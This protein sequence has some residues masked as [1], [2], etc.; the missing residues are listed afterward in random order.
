MSNKNQNNNKRIVYPPI[1]SQ[2]NKQGAVISVVLSDDEDVKWIWTH[3]SNGESFV[4]GYEII[5]KEVLA[6]KINKNLLKPNFTGKWILDLDKSNLQSPP[7]DSSIF[8]INSTLV[9]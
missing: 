3:L 1:N 9:N 7:P 5:K 8:I 4:S 6:G 2:V